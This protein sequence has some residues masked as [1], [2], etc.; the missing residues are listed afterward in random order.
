MVDS[1]GI[2]LCPDPKEWTSGRTS[3]NEAERFVES[4][5]SID[6]LESSSHQELL[7]P[8]LVDSDE[9]VANMVLEKSLLQQGSGLKPSPSVSSLDTI[10]EGKE[11]GHDLYLVASSVVLKPGA[12]HVQVSG[13]VG[14]ISRA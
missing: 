1:V 8:T 6:I 5:E 13:L 11:W 12:N 14:A 10:L 7:S 3:L 2:T 4:L 9:Y